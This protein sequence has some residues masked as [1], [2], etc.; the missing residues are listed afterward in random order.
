MPT[1]GGYE[2]HSIPI[3]EGSLQDRKKIE[4][5][6]NKILQLT[7]SASHKDS[8]VNQDKVEEYKRRIDELVFDLYE[9][10]SKERKIVLE[11]SKA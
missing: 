3:R 1:I 4:I 7:E 9:L 5:L 11:N 8:S 2:L 10:T 6:V